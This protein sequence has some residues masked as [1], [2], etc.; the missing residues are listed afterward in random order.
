[1]RFAQTFTDCLAPSPYLSCSDVGAELA[2]QVSYMNHSELESLLS[3]LKVF[4]LLQIEEE[5]GRKRERERKRHR[6][7]E[8][9]KMKALAKE[10]GKSML[11]FTGKNKKIKKYSQLDC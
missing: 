4:P 5:R 1:M 10:R 2:F 8:I 9:C 3:A 6:K 11:L 7:G